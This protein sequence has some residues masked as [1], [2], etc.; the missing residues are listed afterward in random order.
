MAPPKARAPRRA[1]WLCNCL[2]ALNC[3]R[4][5]SLIPLKRDVVGGLGRTR[6]EADGVSTVGLVFSKPE[7]KT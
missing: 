3:G 5:L 7:V 4:M 6:E 1:L 2:V